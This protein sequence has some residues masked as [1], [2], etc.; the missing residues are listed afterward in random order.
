MNWEQLFTVPSIIFLVPIVAIIGGTAVTIAKM[1]FKHQERLEMIA[2]G[3][4]PDHLPQDDPTADNTAAPAGV[5][6]DEYRAQA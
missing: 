5:A 2:R 6:P 1:F 4:H 3:I